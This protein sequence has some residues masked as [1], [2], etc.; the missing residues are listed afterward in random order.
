LDRFHTFTLNIKSDDRISDVTVFL[1][2]KSL[3]SRGSST[4]SPDEQQKPELPQLSSD[5]EH[6]KTPF[7]SFN[8][9]AIWNSGFRRSSGKINVFFPKWDEERDQTSIGS[10][11]ERPAAVKSLVKS[12]GEEDRWHRPSS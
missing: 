7:N 1:C 6:R 3:N 4:P 12:I 2:S 9:R 11:R 8:Y 10:K 5:L